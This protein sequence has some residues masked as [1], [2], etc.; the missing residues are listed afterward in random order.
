MNERQ[1]QKNG[2][3]RVRR[4]L[5]PSVM[6][7]GPS[8]KRK[9]G[10]FLLPSVGN[11]ESRWVSRT[12]TLYFSPNAVNLLFFTAPHSAAVIDKAEKKENKNR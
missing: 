2:L 9:Q 8:I 5:V 1:L 3:E 6:F 7:G 12:T 4:S 11:N 10:N